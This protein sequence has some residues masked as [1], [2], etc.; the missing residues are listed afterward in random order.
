MAKKQL[1]NHKITI[2]GLLSSF[3]FGLLIGG[4][5]YLLIK[6]FNLKSK[7]WYILFA[8]TPPVIGFII[9]WNSKAKWA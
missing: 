2:V 5:V 9:Y 7:L 6:M 8:F 1:T 3:I 4:I